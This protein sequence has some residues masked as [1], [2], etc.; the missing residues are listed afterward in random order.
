MDQYDDT[1]PWQMI[2]A[3]RAKGAASFQVVRSWPSRAEDFFSNDPG[4]P[5]PYNI[6]YPIKMLDW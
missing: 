6:D 3:E 2:L 4:D 1:A 5:N